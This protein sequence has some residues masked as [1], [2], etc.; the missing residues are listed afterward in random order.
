[1]QTRPLELEVPLREFIP[2]F[3]ELQLKSDKGIRVRKEKWLLNNFMSVVDCWDLG[4][5]NA[6][7][8]HGKVKKQMSKYRQDKP[9]LRKHLMVLKR[10]SLNSQDFGRD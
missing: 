10:Q 9:V 2:S 5:T 4:G 1:M 8:Q 7:I 6:L 3:I